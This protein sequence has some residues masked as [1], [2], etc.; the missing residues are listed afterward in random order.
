MLLAVVAAVATPAPLRDHVAPV[1]AGLRVN[2]RIIAQTEIA[3]SKVH[4]DALVD[5][6]GNSAIVEL[7]AP[8]QSEPVTELE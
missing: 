4:F 8:L 6:S 2:D 1:V 5:P 3:M 7:V